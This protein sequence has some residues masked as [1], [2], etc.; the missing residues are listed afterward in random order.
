[1]EFGNYTARGKERH[2]RGN[3]GGRSSFYAKIMYKNTTLFIF[4]NWKTGVYH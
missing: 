2:T 4:P 1:M 3:R